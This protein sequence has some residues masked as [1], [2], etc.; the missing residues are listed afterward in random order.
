[1]L[2]FGQTL[3]MW[4]AHRRLTQQALAQKARLP[5]PNLSAIERDKRDASLATI[6]MLAAALELNPGALVDG[7]APPSGEGSPRFSRE[8]LE[9]I[10]DAVV[11]G[12][13]PHHPT[14]RTL[15]ELLRRV[16]RYR[17]ALASQRRGLPRGGKRAEESA[18]LTLQASIP[19]A[20]LRSLLERIEDRLRAH[21]PSA[22]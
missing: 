3:R 16:M 22:Y 7:L 9:R 1:M 12:V 21:A 13:R 15:A 5:R 14:E 4:R 10:A 19:A 6:R 11:D 17:L 18:W 2:S 20:L 8:A